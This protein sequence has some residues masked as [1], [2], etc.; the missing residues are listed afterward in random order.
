MLTRNTYGVER[1]NI[2]VGV[3]CVTTVRT[4]RCPQAFT[5]NCV[6]GCAVWRVTALRWLW[7]P[8]ELAALSEGVG[9][10]SASGDHLRNDWVVPLVLH[11]SGDGLDEGIGGFHLSFCLR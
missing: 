2:V 4:S 9:S 8:E 3:G 7:P 1:Y 5:G 10:S 11:D 6:L